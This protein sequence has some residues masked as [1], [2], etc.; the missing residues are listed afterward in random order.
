MRNK[1]MLRGQG[2]PAPL[3]SLEVAARRVLPVEHNQGG[4]SPWNTRKKG[5]PCGEQVEVS[6]VI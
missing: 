1:G 2:Q 6:V 5:A 3:L 4:C